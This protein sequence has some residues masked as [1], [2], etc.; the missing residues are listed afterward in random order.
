MR[1]HISGGCVQSGSH[2]KN[3]D[4]ITYKRELNHS[5]M[6]I[7][8]QDMELPDKYA[9]R[10]L[11]HNH[12]GK[13]LDCSLRR[14]DQE[15]FLYYDITSRQ[16]LERLYEGKKLGMEELGQIIRAIAA[17]QE[18]LEEYL[19]DEQGLMLYVG[20]IF[21]NV[22]TEELY[23]CFY[24]GIREHGS[25]YAE[26]AD[27]FLEHVDHG[28]EHA[29]STAYQFYRMSKADYFVISA[30]LPFL[31]KETAEWKKENC[32]QQW[33]WDAQQ[34]GA[35][36]AQELKETE[37]TEEPEA[38]KKRR[39]WLLRMFGQKRAAKQPDRKE[40][41]WPDTVWDSYEGQMNLSGSQETVYLTDLD[42]MNNGKNVCY[43]LRETDGDKEFLLDDLPL[44]VGKLKGK[45]SVVLSDPSVSRMHAR[46]ENGREGICICDLNSRNGTMVNGKRLS[47]NEVMPI[48][49]GDV[50]RF[51][52][53]SFR[54]ERV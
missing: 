12:I 32:G 43:R 23:F 25:R 52:R 29:V 47:P 14:M 19:L 38:P 33:N 21:A 37:N 8:C 30:I 45:V 44:T 41:F 31:E 50:I 46:F 7:K 49:S 36:P 34:V 20:M 26:L 2:M 53:V 39:S 13:L 22:E 51:G 11:M 16:P 6:V 40:E 54:C 9:Y 1:Y 17:M 35:V 10:I 3:M 24:P 4:E 27:F 15:M 5:Y 18:D 42:R 28:E 48:Q